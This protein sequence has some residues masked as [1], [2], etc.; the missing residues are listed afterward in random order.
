MRRL[1]SLVGL[2]I[3]ALTLPLVL[4]MQPAHAIESP[5]VCL[6][7][8]PSSC[9]VLANG[10][11]TIVQSGEEYEVTTLRQFNRREVTVY[12]CMNGRFE[13]VRSYCV[14][15]ACPRDIIAGDD[16]HSPILT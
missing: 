14:G 13:E 4:T 16:G 11:M 5:D 7:P 2:A 12:R 6:G 10:S 8:C 15:I 1:L 9:Y 3:A